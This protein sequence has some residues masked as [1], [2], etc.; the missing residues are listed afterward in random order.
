MHA[1]LVAMAASELEELRRIEQNDNDSSPSNN[2]ESKKYSPS[3]HQRFP[4]A[5]W[6]L[7]HELSGNDQCVDCGAANPEWAAISYGALLC[8][9]C[10][11]RHRQ[12]G[13]QV[14]V[15]NTNCGTERTL[16]LP[17]FSW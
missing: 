5:C 10:S 2:N 9:E 7:V 14:S 15:S 17:K 6:K 11:G 12:L 1:P 13:V 8:I 16:F 4:S 3:R